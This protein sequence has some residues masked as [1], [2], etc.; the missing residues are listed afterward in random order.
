[1]TAVRCPAGGMPT[2]SVFF[3]IVIRRYYQDHDPPHV[4]A[5]YVGSSLDLAEIPLI[6]PLKGKTPSAVARGLLGAAAAA[7]EGA[8]RTLAVLNV[9]VRTAVCRPLGGGDAV[10]L[11]LGFPWD[12]VPGQILDVAPWL[13]WTEHGRTCLTGRIAG[14]RTDAAALG[15]EPLRLDVRRPPLNRSVTS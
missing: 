5:T 12:V 7:P 10:S 11:R 9:G 14:R 8:L 3:A 4:H 2:V 6:G 13:E 1:M 15:L